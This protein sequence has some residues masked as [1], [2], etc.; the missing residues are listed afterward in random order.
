M[1]VNDM[2]LGIIQVKDRAS[3][4]HPF[5][6]TALLV[7]ALLFSILHFTFYGYYPSMAPNIAQN[8]IISLTLIVASS[9]DLRNYGLPRFFRRTIFFGII[10]I[11][12]AL[13]DKNIFFFRELLFN[14]FLGVWSMIPFIHSIKGNTWLGAV[15]LYAGYLAINNLNTRDYVWIGRRIILPKTRYVYQIFVVTTAVLSSAA[16]RIGSEVYWLARM[17]TR[18]LKNPKCSN[19]NNSSIYLFFR[20]L[21]NSILYRFSYVAQVI[22]RLLEDRGY[23]SD[24]YADPIEHIVSQSDIVALSIIVLGVFSF[25]ILNI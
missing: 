3:L 24:Q 10:L 20:I 9:V 11:S 12:I 13:A 14:Q 7:S 6:K 18:L 8:S 23:F 1:L 5:L 15:N 19:S 25:I 4:S 16:P 2:V 22:E 17:R 21:S